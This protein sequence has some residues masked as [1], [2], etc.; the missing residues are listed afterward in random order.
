MTR[1]RFHH[2]RLS[3]VWMALNLLG[4]KRRDFAADDHGAAAAHD[5]PKLKGTNPLENRQETD[6]RLECRLREL[7]TRV[8][9][10]LSVK[11]SNFDQYMPPPRIV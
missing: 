1:Q 9:R 7:Q 3:Q 11:V 6:R 4:H 2:F 10:A 5:E 8:P